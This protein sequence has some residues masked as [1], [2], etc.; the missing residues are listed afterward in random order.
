MYK[1]IDVSK[2]NGSLNWDVL[3]KNGVDFAIIRIGWGNDSTN[4]DDERALEN[5]KACE[6]LNIPYGVYIYSYA[7]TET[8]VKSEVKHALRMVN[9]RNPELGVWFDMEDADNYKKKNGLN[10][11]ENREVLTQFCK[12]FCDEIAKAGYK[13]GIYANLDYCK[14]VLL[15]ISEYNLW[16]AQWKVKNPGKDCLMWQYSSEGTFEGHSCKFDM[17]YFYGE[18]PKKE[19]L[20]SI[21]EVAKEVIAGKW[22]NGA[23][24]KKNLENAGY[25]YIDVQAKVNE[26]MGKAQTNKVEATYETYTVK[27]GDT[28]WS[29][30]EAKLGKG[31]RYK[32]IKTLNGLTSDTIYPGDV[33]KIPR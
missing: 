23:I 19:T 31:N 13:T 9:G 6:K 14:N 16:L 24:R 21:E 3:K 27:K 11:Y 10:P 32:E 12:I 8:E 33:L 28:L 22:G 17:N 2:H 1:G 18:L 4:Q 29:I 30:A 20:K 26:L 15:D 25:K 7:L 5:M